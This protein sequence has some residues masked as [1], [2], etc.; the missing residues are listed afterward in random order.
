M[1]R[2]AVALLALV[3]FAGN[4]RA[5]HPL[6]HPV[7]AVEV[8]F[9]QRQPVIAYTLRVDSADLSGFGVELRIRNAPD[10][11]RLAMMAHPEYDDRYWRYLEGIHAESRVSQARPAA[12]TR[13][14]S[15]LWRVVAPGGEVTVRYR[16][17]LP[18]ADNAMRGAWRPFLA[19]TGGLVGGPHSFLYV[20]GS[21]L[22]PVHVAL[23]LP[24]SW[25]IAT[26]L[27]PSADRHH[28]FA[29]SADVLVDAPIL[30]GRLANWSFVADDVPH[31]I[32]YWARPGATQFD[33]TAFAD[34][35]KRLVDQTLLLFGRAP[36]RE[37][38][39]LVQ[40]GAYGA[41]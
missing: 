4:A 26:G 39:F 3:A 6:S 33:T 23:E 40:D 36:Y 25:D 8:R 24:S 13:E 7:D 29:P 1:P 35:V 18:V 22:A 19:P 15:A 21:T 34:G 12:V 28:Y 10:T 11:F 16:I 37:Y 27:V 38:A 20:V 14:D 2:T 30:V 41:L 9:A 32:V 5:Q 31:R 17:R